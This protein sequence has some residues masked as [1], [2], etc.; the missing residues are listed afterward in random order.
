MKTPLKITLVLSIVAALD[1][2]ALG[3]PWRGIVPLRSTKTDVGRV[4]G[5]PLAED[6]LG[7]H[8]DLEN[9]YVV[10]TVAR[11]D[12]S[13]DC[14]TKLAAGTVIRIAVTPKRQLQLAELHLREA[15]FSP[16]EPFQL[17]T[18][19]YKAY[20]DDTEGL[21]VRTY[22]EKVDRIVYMGEKRDQGLC[23]SYYHDVTLMSQ[24]I[25]CILCP[26][27]LVTSPSD[28]TAGTPIT[29]TSNV[30]VGSSPSPLKYKWSV[31]AGAIVEGQDTDSIKVAS[32]GLAGKTVT[33]T[34]EITGIDSA[35]SRTASSTTQ[36]L[37]RKN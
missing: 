24:R 16:F 14:A 26:T 34:V 36:I 12:G 32:E 35:C 19:G 15:H 25:L 31:S 17:L 9:E 21:I 37:P 33:A 6:Q 28:V 5:K 20:V 11:P 30:T 13:E 22:H 7:I 2:S 3:K 29:F 8:Y 1:C 23:F 27:I 18:D 4:L 10:I